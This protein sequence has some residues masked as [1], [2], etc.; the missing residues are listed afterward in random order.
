M[1]IMHWDFVLKAIP[2]ILSEGL[3]NTLRLTLVPFVLA[4]IIGVIVAV[5]KIENVPVLKQ[6]GIVY[7]SIFK[8]TPLMVQIL[9]FY[10]GFPMFLNSYKERFGLNINV[11]DIPAINYMFVVFALCYGAYISEVMRSAIL[12][13]DNGQSEAA[14]TIGMSKFKS[15]YRVIFPQALSNAIPNLGNYFVDLIK[16]TSLAF[17][18]TVV[19]ILASAKILGGRE[20]KYFEAYIAA[21]IIYWVLCTLFQLLFSRVEVIFRRYERSKN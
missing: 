5:I 15:F 1:K 9:I 7:T 4:C 14:Y 19:E 12:S 18:A 11:N 3:Y 20:Y 2:I 16:G 13:V 17:S 8:G 6:I 21:A 10:Y